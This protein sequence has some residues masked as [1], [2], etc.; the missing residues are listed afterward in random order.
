MKPLA[1][2]V[3]LFSFCVTVAV[4]QSEQTVPLQ[5]T[6]LEAFVTPS[7]ARVAWSKHVGQIVEGETQAIVTAIVIEDRGR[8]PFLMRGVRIN[9]KNDKTADQVYL[10]ESRLEAAA[11]YIRPG[12]SG[13]SLS[14]YKAEE[15]RFPT[16]RP[17]ELADLIGRATRELNEQ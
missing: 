4:A 11:Y 17:I 14:A 6:P 10:D 3:A 16:H 7:S 1:V 8:S 13:L 9:L 15:F 12:S 2:P 5:P